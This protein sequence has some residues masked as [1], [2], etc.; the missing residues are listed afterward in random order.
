MCAA[1]LVVCATMSFSQIPNPGFENWATDVDGNNNPVSWETI[2]SFPIVS[3]EPV[4]PGH[5]GT[6]AMKVK[7]VDLTVVTLGFAIAQAPYTFAETPT[8]FSAWVKSTLMPGDT[9]L[10]IVALMRGDS[11]IAATDSCTFKIDSSYAQFT[12]L[13]F[14]IAVISSLIPDSLYVMV[15]TGLGA[16]QVGTE[17]IVDDIA[18]IFG[19]PTSVS[20]EPILPDLFRLAQNYPNPF[21]PSTE[22]SFDLPESG[23]TTLEVYDLLG[24]QVATL[25][26]GFLSAGTHTRTLNAEHLPS[27]VYV[28]Q[29]RSGSFQATRRLMVVK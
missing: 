12:Y 5:G 23:I 1:A 20:K 14:P 22:I 10:I 24:R 7:T 2:N 6:Y 11:V 15:A 18:F 21:N 3:V 28:Y 4:T 8:K 27:G 9:A 25:V 17:L 19:N 26:S 29:L 13:E 16:S